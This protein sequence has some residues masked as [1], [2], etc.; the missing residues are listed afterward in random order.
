M[1]N[2]RQTALNILMKV[3]QN[4][5]Y[6]NLLLDSTLEG[7]L[8]SELDKKYIS[9][10]V[11]GVIERKKL[12]DYNLSIYLSSPVKKLK[13]HVLNILRIGA[14][15]IFFMSKVHESATVN[16][17]VKLT[18]KNSCS[19]ASG[20]VNAVLRKISENGISYC[21]DL[22]VKYSCEKWICDEWTSHFG[23]EE[24][25]RILE[26]SMGVVPIYI[27]TNTLKTTVHDLKKELLN[28]NIE[29]E[30]VLHVPDALKILKQGNIT[31]T[32]CFK[33]GLFHVQDLSSQICS[34]LIDAKKGDRILDVCSA[35]GGK[36]FTIAEIMENYGMVVSCDIYPQRLNLV[37]QGASRLGIDIIETQ[38]ND[39][40]I[41]N[42]NFGV[43]D[44][45]LCDV[46][47]SGLGILRRKPE[48][49]YKSQEDIDKLSVLQYHIM[50]VSSSYVKSG[51]K[52]V[53]S[54][55]SLNRKENEYNCCKFLSDNKDFK[56]CNITSYDDFGIVN[57]NMINILPD[58]MDT[59]GFFAA[60]F[61]R[62]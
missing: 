54:T 50:C 17:C 35:P 2:A 11:Y 41:F 47:C 10:V 56:K 6:S 55:C 23:R 3:T 25:V 4:N 62:M 49:R 39:A 21:D 37:S 40:E 36:S 59:D 12:L 32:R 53:Y 26:N 1:H 52:F 20:L 45:V 22:S 27:R 19:Y 61:E 31:K 42:D 60:V 29:S 30:E 57:E 5:S 34:K 38:E 28:E 43:F 15:E 33:N 24:T 51:G 18:K 58:R 7:E 44:K 8:L 16:E 13:P 48:I 14:Y 9:A 46:P